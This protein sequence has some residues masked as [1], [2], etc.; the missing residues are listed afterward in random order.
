MAGSF[1]LDLQDREEVPRG[2]EALALGEEALVLEVEVEVWGRERGA[3]HPG[4]DGGPKTCLLS[5]VKACLLAH[6]AT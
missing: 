4:G 3:P 6:S 5:T 2:E 1:L